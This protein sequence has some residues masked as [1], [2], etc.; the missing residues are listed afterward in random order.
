MAQNNKLEAIQWVLDTK[1]EVDYLFDDNEGRVIGYVENKQIDKL[2]SLQNSNRELLEALEKAKHIIS[3][4][5][6]A[7]TYL[8]MMDTTGMPLEIERA[9]NNAKERLYA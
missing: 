5:D 8:A 4:S 7:I 9:I 6:Y 3:C 2:K 1:M